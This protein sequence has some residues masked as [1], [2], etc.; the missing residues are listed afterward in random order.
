[1]SNQKPLVA[2][3]P[4]RLQAIQQA[5]MEKLAGLLPPTTKP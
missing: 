3:E 4:D 2:I 1:M 5:Y